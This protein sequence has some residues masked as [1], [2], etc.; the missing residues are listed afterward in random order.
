[1][2]PISSKHL[3]LAVLAIALS[4]TMVPA[5]ALA[6]PSAT[7]MAQARELLNEG[8]DLRD[9]GDASGALEKLRGAHALANTPITGLELGRTYM[10]LG[11]LVEARETFLS[12]ARIAPRPDETS[13]SKTARAESQKLADQLRGRIPSLTVKVTGVPV[14]TVSV[15]IDGAMVPTDALVAPRLLNPG[16]HTVSARSTTGGTA[17]TQVTLK[18]GET[19]EVELK[20]TF[21]PASEAAHPQLTGAVAPPAALP[22]SAPS[23]PRARSHALDGALIG[24][25]AAIAIAGG[26]LMAVEIGKGNDAIDRQDHSA[27]QSSKTAWT[28]GLVGTVVGGAVAASGIVLLASTVSAKPATTT[29]SAS[30]WV[31]AGTNGVK[32][33]GTW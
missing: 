19:R 18:E 26:V 33:G 8:L 3:F 25:G 7:D 1:M 21:S 27:W 16:A 32:F 15:A 2:K 17:E 30:F 4:S 24:G 29:G 5:V 11:K 9:K 10:D 22:E 28:A 13:H 20:I 23:E 14:E 6:A 12:V 31:G